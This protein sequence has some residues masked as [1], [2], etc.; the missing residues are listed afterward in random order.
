MN[1]ESYTPVIRGYARVSTKSQASDGS[2]L[3]AQ[4][5]QLREAGAS[6]IYKDAFSGTVTDR[7]SFDKLKNDLRSGDTL[8]VC[9][10][11]R[12]ARTATEGTQL[13]QELLNKG[14]SVHVLNM[15]LIDN[16]PTGKLIIMIMLAFAEFE[17]DMIIER[18]QAG[19]VNTGKYGGRPCVYSKIQ[20]KHALDLL[21][22]GYSYREIEELTGISKSTLYRFK[23]HVSS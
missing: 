10:L 5:K 3:E 2:S 20:K 4:E 7:P 16:T 14:I 11:D 1:K 8:I 12:F 18:T 13:I 21:E 23:Q 17:R 22:Q 15:G 9:K 19:R 6:I